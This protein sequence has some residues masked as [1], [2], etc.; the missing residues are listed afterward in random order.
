M[1]LDLTNPNAFTRERVCELIGS[2]DDSKN[3]QL[4]VSKNG[5]G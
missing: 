2:G 3:Y 5:R 4:R 1:E